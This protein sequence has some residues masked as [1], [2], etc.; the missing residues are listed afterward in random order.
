M[1]RETGFHPCTAAQTRNFGEVNG[2][3]LPVDFPQY[4]AMEEYWACRENAVMIDLSALRKFEI[5]GPDAEAFTQYCLP[6]DVRRLGTGQVSYSALCYPNGGMID[7][8]TIFRLGRDNFRWVCGTDYSGDWLRQQAREGGF[9]VIIK[10]ATEQLHNV[11]V[12]GPN[13][14]EIL[15]RIVWTRPDQPT[16][17]ELRL[18]RFA[19]GRLHHEDGIPVIV[20]RTGYTGELGYEVFCHPDNAATV[21]REIESAGSDLGLKPMGTAAMD[22]LRIEAGLVAA[23][24]EFDDQI[25][26]FEAGIGFTVPK[27][28]TDPFIGSE[29]L[30]R[31]REAPQ[32]CLVGLDIAAEEP[33]THGD[34]VFLGRQQIGVVTSGVR[35]PIL[36]KTIALARVSVEHGHVGTDLEIGKLDGLQKRLSATVVPAPHFDPGKER[37]KM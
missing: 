37:M 17:D 30:T 15:K 20:S 35:S 29:A 34:G 12:Q 26:P 22:M 21:W 5:M 2:F 27:N 16:M 24:H 33:A 11:S 8:G 10:S 1:T 32:R 4:G 13:S 36:G 7:D 23:G 9:D 14:R 19:I 25:D 6:R 18:F 31:R 28:K 3:W